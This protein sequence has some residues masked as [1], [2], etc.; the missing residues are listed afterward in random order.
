MR[1]AASGPLVT[2]GAG[3][4]RCCSSPLARLGVPLS[5]HTRAAYHHTSYCKLW[6]HGLRGEKETEVDI[7][8][9]SFQKMMV[10]TL[11]FPK[12]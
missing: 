10:I 7:N 3:H 1:D 4:F 9:D 8:T 2:S 6:G 5:L 11:D 12:K